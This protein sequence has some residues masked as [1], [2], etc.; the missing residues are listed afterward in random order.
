MVAALGRYLRRYGEHLL[1]MEEDD[2]RSFDS[3]GRRQSHIQRGAETLEHR[4]STTDPEELSIRASMETGS[5]VRKRFFPMLGWCTC[6]P[7]RSFESLVPAPRPI[8]N[9]NSSFLPMSWSTLPS[10]P[11]AR[12]LVAWRNGSNQ[13]FHPSLL[14]IAGKF[15]HPFLV[16]VHLLWIHRVRHDRKQPNHSPLPSRSL[17]FGSRSRGRV[18]ME[19][20]KGFVLGD[21]SARQS[22][23]DKRSYRRATMRSDSKAEEEEEEGN[24]EEDEQVR[25]S[26]KQRKG[27][28]SIKSVVSRPTSF[29]RFKPT[30]RFETIERFDAHEC[31]SLIHDALKRNIKVITSLICIITSN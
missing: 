24:P 7:R 20:T 4:R 21:R 28:D 8:A 31:P 29:P 9:A 30:Q 17:R 2:L 16:D 10:P 3:L 26:P 27:V 13:A 12:D 6:L 19:R 18:S 14:I 25:P 15:H 22:A 23:V 5:T 11:R 1:E